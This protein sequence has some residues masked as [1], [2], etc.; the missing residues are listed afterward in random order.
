MLI[1]HYSIRKIYP[2][3]VC[4]MARLF[5]YLSLFTHQASCLLVHSFLIIYPQIQ[6]S[7]TFQCTYRTTHPPPTSNPHHFKT[8]ASPI[9]SRPDPT[10]SEEEEEELPQHL[11][12][13][14]D[15]STGPLSNKPQRD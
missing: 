10:L 5:S 2:P 1:Y 4:L 15:I 12:T 3:F 14:F 13:I 7:Q 9:P 6:I 11:L 8:T